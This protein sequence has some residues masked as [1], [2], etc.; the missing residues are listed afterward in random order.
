MTSEIK[1]IPSSSQTVGPYFSIG[2]QYLIDRMAEVKSLAERSI[3]IRG[4]VLDRDG[5]P[6]PDAMLE[7]WSVDD[8]KRGSA[9]PQEHGIPDGFLRVV[10]DA[11]GSFI[12]RIARP[13]ANRLDGGGQVPPHAL[14]LVY[15]RGLQRNLITR[16]YLGDQM[17]NEADPVMSR[18]PAE[19]RGTLTAKCDGAGAYRWDVVLQG[20]DETVFFAW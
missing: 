17:T 9:G 16:V 2:L 6:V 3:E 4:K 1:R 20:N 19:R 8:G 5:V 10:T 14:V 11:E 12:A 15:A 18:V 13:V 7:F